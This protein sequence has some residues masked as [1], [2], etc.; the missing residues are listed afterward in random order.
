MRFRNAAGLAVAALLSACGGGVTRD[1]VDDRPP[2]APIFTA[3]PDMPF[4]VDAGGSARLD[5]DV[6]EP[7]YVVATI[8][9]Q[10]L[11]NSLLAV[12]TGRGCHSV[13]D[14]LGWRCA[15]SEVS[16]HASTCAAKPRILVHPN[17][18][19]VALQHRHHRGGRQGDAHAVP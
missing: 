11:A 7:G 19:P 15:T 4:T 17:Y 16:D 14:A 18:A 1:P 3:L 6:P 12:F 9:W 5:F 8:D 2:P 13:N 10:D